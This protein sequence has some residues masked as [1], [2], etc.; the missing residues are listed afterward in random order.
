M[1]WRLGIFEHR[2]QVEFSEGLGSDVDEAL[3]QGAGTS[4]I[5]RL[6]FCRKTGPE[7]GKFLAVNRPGNLG[8]R[9]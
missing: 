1:I 3:V 8:S 2:A 6:H 5:D 9:G 4:L 7:F